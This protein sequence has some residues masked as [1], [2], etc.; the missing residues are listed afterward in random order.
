[1]KASCKKIPV[2]KTVT[3]RIVD[4]T[5]SKPYFVQV[6]NRDLT[7]GDDL[8]F[9]VDQVQIQRPAS[10]KLRKAWRYGTWESRLQVSK[11]RSPS[12]ERVEA[13]CES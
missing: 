3:P 11:I 6:T 8:D 1:M 4:P 5:R 7:P 10:V 12:S 13:G 9:D 2:V